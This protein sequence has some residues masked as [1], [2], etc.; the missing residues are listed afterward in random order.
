[1]KCPYCGANMAP[2]TQKCDYCGMYNDNWVND[3]SPAEE[4]RPQ[5]VVYHIHHHY[6]EYDEE[7]PRRSVRHSANSS[8]K[9]KWFALVLCMLFG[10]FGIHRF[11]VGKFGT[12]LIYLLTG[13][14]TGLGT[15]IDFFLILFGRF[16]DKNGDPLQ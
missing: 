9:N 16:T 10:V 8:Q 15:I 11:Y 2:N 5:H 6:N 13:G 4:E 7:A 1:M 14:L 3:V 12:G